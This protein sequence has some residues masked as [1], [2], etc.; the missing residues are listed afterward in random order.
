MN[1]S[2]RLLLEDF[3]SLMREEGELDIF[4]PLLMS[5]MGHEVVYRAQKGTRQ[6]GVDISSIGPDTDGQ[7]KLFLWLVKCGDINR[8][9]WDSGP[10]SIRQSINDVGIYLRSHVAPQHKSLKKKLLVVTNGDFN[11]S[12]N[13]TIAAF[14]EDWSKH[15]KVQ[16]E[17]VNGSTLAAWTEQNLLDEY[18]LPAENRALLRRMLANVASPDLCVSVGR[19]LIDAMVKSASEPSK[20]SGARKKKLLTGL[21]GIRTALSVLQVWAQNEENLQAPYRLAE[22]AILAVWAK[23]N[24][25]ILKGEAALAREFDALLVKL[26]QVAAA[27]HQR[28]QPY[29]VVQD[30]FAH[31]LPDSLLI[32]KTVFDEIGRLGLQGCLCAS[33]TAK[34]KL[35]TEEEMAHFYAGH[36]E[37]LLQSHSCSALPPYD[38]H[39]V[40]VHLGLLLL[41]V[42]GRTNAARKWVQQLCQRLGYAASARKFWPMSAP[43]E[44]AV[45][46]RHGYEEM[47]GDFCSTSTL[48][49]VLLTWT[50]TLG[51]N[52]GYAFLREQIVP[53]AKGTTPNFWSSDKGF[54][55]VVSDPRAL[56]EHGVGEAVME[57][58]KAPEEFLKMMSVALA[59]VEPIE[60]SVWYQMRAA[61]IPMLAALHWESQLPREML[62]QQAIAFAEVAP[63]IPAS[64]NGGV[65]ANEQPFG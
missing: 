48:I 59:D 43:F 53:N 31:A 47:E 7:I 37:A 21:R 10:Q 6:Y 9:D 13:E 54:D 39:S 46:I 41:V 27:Y 1:T 19:S 52:E 64:V 42:T 61:Y 23:L 44:D 40:N 30:A 49:P 29:Y 32:S 56:H 38:H 25:E 60:S 20:S 2:L 35:T 58:P 62:V 15:K 34:K 65:T 12:L 11:A 8:I 17:Q 51:L 50:A 22:Y 55:A 16:A 4:L 36:L 57:I 26:A 45:R 24:Q 14:L 33:Q 63:I 18:I 3:L 28:V 5:A